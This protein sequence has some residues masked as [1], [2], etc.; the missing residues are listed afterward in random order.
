LLLDEKERTLFV[1]IHGDPINPDT[2]TEYARRYIQ[3]AGIEKG[4]AC[5][6]FRH[7]MATL[8]HENG[9]DI[10]SIQA[11][12]GHAK[13]DTTQIYTRVSL[14][15]LLKVHGDTHPAERVEKES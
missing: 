8:M 11:I 9:A 5:H 3:A 1:T 12:L 13:L 14:R 15:N 4:G 2:L 10:R 6:I 7:T